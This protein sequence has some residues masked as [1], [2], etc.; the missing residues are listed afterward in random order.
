MKPAKVD[1]VPVRVFGEVIESPEP[2]LPRSSA[3]AAFTEA[4]DQ[5]STEVDLR[6][7]TEHAAES[8]GRSSI[9]AGV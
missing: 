9:K 2:R 3:R 7:M 6:N 5:K 8:G 4:S 1:R